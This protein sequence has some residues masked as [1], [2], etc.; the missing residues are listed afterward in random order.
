MFFDRDIKG[1][2][3]PPGTLCLTYDDG[4]SEPPGPDTRELG[5]FLHEQGIAATFFA[6]GRHAAVCPSLVRQLREWGHLVGNHTWSHPGLVSLALSGGDVV[7]E[8]ERTDATLGG[9]APRGLVYVRAPYGNWRETEG[10]GGPEKP[11]SVVAG[12]LNGSRRFP[13]H[14]G[15]VNWDVCA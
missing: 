4:P 2:L 6:V 9:A 1:D 5:R 12:L 7:G 11:V 13:R 3:L 15:P 8:L 14:V 10:P